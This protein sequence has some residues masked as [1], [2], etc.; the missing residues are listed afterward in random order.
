MQKIAK[1]GVVMLSRLLGFTGLRK[2]LQRDIYVINYHSI[3]GID[4]DPYI[5]NEVYRTQEEFE[6]DIVFY[7][8]H[9]NIIS[10]VDL[11]DIINNGR[12]IQKNSLILTFDDGLR[13]NLDIHIPILKRHNVP[14][15][16][17]L[18]SAFIDNKDLH[19]ARKKNLILQKIH[20]DK[21]DLLS[22]YLSDHKMYN[23]EVSAS[24]K[25]I[26]YRE[27]VHLEELAKMLKIDFKAYLLENAPYLSSEEI[28]CI[29]DE[30]FFIGAHSIDH[31]RYTE[32][33]L[34]EQVHQTVESLRFV[35]ERFNLTY[36]LF[37]FPYEDTMLTKEFYSRIRPYV[38]LTF[39][40]KGFVDDSI[41]FSIQRS[42]VESTQL[43][44]VEALKYRFLTSYSYVLF[45]DK[46]IKRY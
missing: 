16:F 19:F 14:A 39:G 9:F 45:K 28:R 38:D 30:G 34:E 25:A 35:T 41:D 17:F 15:T 33:S 44:A 5:K 26:N 46:K 42:E 36:R 7:L 10:A 20:D 43:P 11:I 21:A 13:V 29:I 2:L 22:A 18:N 40:T 1:D 4:V 24:I 32:L 23:G 8:K 6:K 12:P 3:K 31:P 27:K 37:A